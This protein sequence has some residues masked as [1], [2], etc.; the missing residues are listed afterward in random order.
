MNILITNDDGIDS[1]GIR[2]LAKII[3][4]E[5]KVIVAAPHAERSAC[6]HSITL[7]KP[8][9][10]KEEKLMGV[11]SKAYSIDGTPADCV[12]IGI[13]KLAK[14][15][16]DLII[17][18]INRGYNLGV[19]VLYSGT[20]SAAVEGALYR[21]PS[22]AISTQPGSK[23]EMEKYYQYAAKALKEIIKLL[24]LKGKIN[25]YNI[26]VPG[27]Q[28]EYIKGTV[29][30]PLANQLYSNVFTELDEAK[31]LY[32]LTGSVI[33]LGPTDRDIHYIEEGYITI[34]PIKYD[35]TDYASLDK[36]RAIFN[37]K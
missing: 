23:A 35:L 10:V 19:D 9:T 28:E 26:N 8:L 17:S 18:G 14:V 27:I 11:F 33:D 24:P 22:I 32:N 29:V 12:R 34:T 4:E 7:N 20:V 13:E 3:E 5:H 21:I 6:G 2:L 16:V 15:K 1:L 30:C 25:L 31:E 36:L 37:D